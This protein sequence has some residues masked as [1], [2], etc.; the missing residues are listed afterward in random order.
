MN[1]DHVRETLLYSG[2]CVGWDVSCQT[3][4]MISVRLVISFRTA[5]STRVPLLCSVLGQATKLT[6][7]FLYTL[8]QRRAE[9]SNEPWQCEEK[10]G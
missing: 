6:A 1:R 2:D 8:L 9:H 4:I 10:T 5:G 3:W 7:D